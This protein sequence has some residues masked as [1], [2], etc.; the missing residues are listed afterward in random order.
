MKILVTGGAGF[1]GS[2][3]V[4]AYIEEGH[5]VIV[6]DDLSTGN[7]DNLNP[8]ARFYL[9]DIR[10]REMERL[11]QLEKPDIINHQAAQ[12]SVPLSTQ[13]PVFDAHVNIL[14]TIN[15]LKAGT[16]YG[17]KRFIFASTGGAIYGDSGGRVLSEESQPAPESPYATSKLSAE[18]YIELLSSGKFSYAILRYANVYGPRQIPHG[19]AGVVAIF[20]LKLIASKPITI[21]TYPDMERGMVRDY[22]FVKDVAK[23]NLLA[24]FGNDNLIVNIS[25]GNGTDTLTLL[26]T[27]MK[28]AGKKVKYD[29][30]PPRPGDI[31]YSIL[32][33]ERAR[34][35]LG[36]SPEFSL[37]EGL[38]KT[39]NYF[40]NRY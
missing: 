34:K 24:T 9:L 36:W 26:E 16:N 13:D 27:L 31:R 2:H 30:G 11:I 8:E 29:F 3:I 25:T 39:Y 5:E 7:P 20:S 12:I 28:I 35:L 38:R 1:I 10:S 4:D 19:E 6:V 22:V 33:S 23:A 32:S 21:Y 14:G 18:K 40:L 37:E 15:L 17:I